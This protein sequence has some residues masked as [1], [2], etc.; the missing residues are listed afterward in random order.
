MKYIHIQFYNVTKNK[1]QLFYFSDP[2]KRPNAAKLLKHPFLCSSKPIVRKNAPPPQPQPVC[3]NSPSGASF[4]VIPPPLGS[5][6]AQSV[7]QPPSPAPPV[8]NLSVSTAPPKLTR[9]QSSR[10]FTTRI[11][12]PLESN[13][14]QN[15]ENEKKTVIFRVHPIKKGDSSPRL[16]SYSNNDLT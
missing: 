13:D 14:G 4:V 15:V 8:L 2:K 16:S 11:V 10:N 12:I 5:S 6:P 3:S 7:I 1:S 9:V